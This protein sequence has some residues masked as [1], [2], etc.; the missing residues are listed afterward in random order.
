ML[1]IYSNHPGGNSAH[2]HKTIEFDMVGRRTASNCT[3]LQCAFILIFVARD[4]G[5]STFS[6]KTDNLQME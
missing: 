3:A 4:L 2:K 1:T 5:T 6:D